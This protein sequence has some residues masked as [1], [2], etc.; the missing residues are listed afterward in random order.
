MAR[1]AARISMRCSPTPL[2]S[3][4]ASCSTASSRAAA[5]SLGSAR[6]VILALDLGATTGFAIAGADA[7][8]TS[9]TAE[10]RLDRWQSGGMRFLRFK[11][12]LTELKNQAGG[13]DLV[14][15]EQVRRHAGVDASHAF[16]GW[17]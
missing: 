4:P 2:S 3:C 9:G 8:I 1:A 7:G 6:D 10:F 15:Y 13:F 14:V 5:L 16:G 11:R 12:W 17:L